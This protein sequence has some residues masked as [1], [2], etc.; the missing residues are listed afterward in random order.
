MAT[1]LVPP[2]DQAQAQIYC[3]VCDANGTPSV[4]LVREMHI[5]K[6]P[7]GHQYQSVAD[8]VNRGAK[9]IPMPLNEQPP[10]T[11]IKWQIWVHPKVKELLEQRYRGRLIATLDVL[12]SSLA[13]GNVLIMSGPDV[14]K[15]KARGLNNGAQIVAALESQ[16]QFEKERQQLMDKMA[17][18]EEIFRQARSSG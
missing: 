17:K 1:N 3:P 6:C 13:D 5:C 14:A 8:A 18:Y 4:P 11:S 10:I 16:D 2:L 9:M 15:L 7:F 12:M